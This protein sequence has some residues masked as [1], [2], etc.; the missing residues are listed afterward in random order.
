MN[1]FLFPHLRI[2][3]FNYF[4]AKKNDSNNNIFTAKKS[5]IFFRTP[6]VFL[7]RKAMYWI[8]F[9]EEIENKQPP[10]ETCILSPE[11]RANWALRITFLALE[12]RQTRNNKTEP[13]MHATRR[14]KLRDT[15]IQAAGP[16]HQRSDTPQTAQRLPLK[17]RGLK[18]NCTTTGRAQRKVDSGVR[19]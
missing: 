4:S 17:K 10:L 5:K 15:Y 1:Y 6:I 7:E 18:K 11:K 8:F 2:M 9:R 14:E 13:C 19:F 3:Y 12:S 16:T